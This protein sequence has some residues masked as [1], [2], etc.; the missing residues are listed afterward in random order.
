MKKITLLLLPLIMALPVKGEYRV[1]QYYVK[2]KVP[3]I[4]D[5]KA[6]VVTSTLD[7][8]SYVAYHGGST[9]IK[10]DQLKSWMCKGDT[11]KKTVCKAPFDQLAQEDE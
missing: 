6:Y 11:S 1:Y 7:P 2:S 9:A 3:T 8:V 10:I 5:V 4:R